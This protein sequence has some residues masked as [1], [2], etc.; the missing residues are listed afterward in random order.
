MKTAFSTNAFINYSLLDSISHISKIGFFATEIVVDEPHSFLPLKKSYIDEIKKHLKKTNL[1]VSNINANTVSGWH[2][3]KKLNNLEK[4]EPSLSTEN[5]IHRNWRI[6]YTKMAIK[7]AYD[8]ESPSICLTSGILNKNRKEKQL[9]FFENSLNDVAEFAE[10]YNIKIALEYEPGL[11][12]GSSSDIFSIISKYKN[13]GLNLDTCHAAVLG[14]NIS[15]IITTAQEKLF[16][17]HFSDCKNK[18]HHHLLPG[19]GDIDFNNMCNALAQIGYD[20]YLT[21]ELYTYSSNP[22]DAARYTLTYLDNL[23]DR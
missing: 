8:L 3:N 4:F 23:T 21:A 9:S 10:K 17:I 5:Y 19:K 15:E 18:T 12:I 11:L 14:E 22:I 20:G 7:I 16:H 6:D 1:R 13:V 2:E